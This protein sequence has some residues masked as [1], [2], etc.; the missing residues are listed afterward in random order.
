MWQVYSGR[1]K[2]RT[3]KL[4]QFVVN[5]ETRLGIKIDQG[6]IDVAAAAE[7]LGHE[8]SIPSDTVQAIESWQ[9]TGAY[10]E[11]LVE[12]VQSSSQQDELLLPERELSL[13]SCVSRPSK[14]ICI[15]L[16]YK[17]HAEETNSPVP[18]S[19]IVF[20]KF[21]NTL[22]GHGSTVTLPL[23][24]VKVDYEAELAI[25]IGRRAQ[26]VPRESA[27]EY[28][29]GYCN[30]NDLSARDLQ[31]KTSQWTL[32]KSC[33]GFAPVGPYLVTA[34]EVGNPN[35]LDIR[36]IV[37]G[38]VRQ[39]SNTSD[40]IFACDEIVSYLSAHMTLEPGDIILTGT[41]EGVVMGYPP[42]RQVYL[43]DGDVVTIEI[44]KLGALTNLM[45]SAQ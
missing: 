3:M 37:N 44:E 24:S 18:T 40:M 15:G 12:A 2:G 5:G 26:D 25:V 19:P 20:N 43:K 35:E 6:V 45:R 9:N 30:A 23:L 32:G 34:D 33:D 31:L 13:V 28:I 1:S 4:I 42:E 29:F 39:D 22:T 16:N 41:P 36:C 14:I 38:E 27:L 17:R 10:L 7:R 21:N 8:G 11:R